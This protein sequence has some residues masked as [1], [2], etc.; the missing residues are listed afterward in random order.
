M[1]H[2]RKAFTLVELLVVVAIIGLLAG[3][4]VISVNSIRT[5]GRDV[6]RVGDLKQLY[7]LLAI[8]ANDMSGETLGDCTTGSVI[9][10]CTKPADPAPA[11]PFDFKAFKDPTGTLACTATSTSPCQYA[12]GKAPK[13]DD[14]EVCFFLETDNNPVGNRG[15]YHLITDGSMLPGCSNIPQQ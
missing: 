4:T 8:Y 5:K 6:R 13:T 15:L 11:L 2:Y 9:Q 12:M 1:F 10:L 14:Y 3:I 7:K